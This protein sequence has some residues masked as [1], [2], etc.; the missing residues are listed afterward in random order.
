MTH[1][2]PEGSLASEQQ[3]AA[4][5]CAEVV[6]RDNKPCS[7]PDCPLPDLRELAEDCCRLALNTF[8]P[9]RVEE[10]DWQKAIDAI[11]AHLTGTRATGVGLRPAREVAHEAITRMGGWCVD[12]EHTALCE[13]FTAAIEADR[14]SRGSR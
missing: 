6:H 7:R 4:P 14:T 1:K 2:E 8:G 10:A 9:P 3:G 5:A 11:Q 13:V 12:T